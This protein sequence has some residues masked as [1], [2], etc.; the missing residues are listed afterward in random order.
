MK[1]QKTHPLTYTMKDYQ[2]QPDG[3]YYEF[4]LLKVKNPDVYIVQKVISY[5]ILK[6][7]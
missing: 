2:N 6:F 4:S 7:T 5:Y 1:V 3:G